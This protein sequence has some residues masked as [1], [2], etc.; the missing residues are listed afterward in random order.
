M[1]KQQDPMS[2]R[3]S[4]TTFWRNSQ[5]GTTAKELK[6]VQSVPGQPSNKVERKSQESEQVA[7]SKRRAQ[8]RK[9]QVQHRQRKADYVK[10]LEDNIAGI[11][12]K[13]A[14]AEGQRQML[15]SENEAIRA[16]LSAPAGFDQALAPENGFNP[17][18][19]YLPMLDGEVPMESFDLDPSFDLDYFP[20]DPNLNDYVNTTTSFDTL[21]LPSGTTSGTGSSVYG[22]LGNSDTSSPFPFIHEI[23]T[24]QPQ[25]TMDLF[26]A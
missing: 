10:Q 12:D 1:T 22:S 16:Q 21:D 6:F 2:D 18:P 14:D 5:N 7:K 15:R 3:P 11:R 8:V 19:S 20:M 25:Q 23:A 13:I 17:L 4:F 9:A 26:L 24:D